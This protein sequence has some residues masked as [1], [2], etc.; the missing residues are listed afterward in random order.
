M[1]L[2]LFQTRIY[3]QAFTIAALC[4]AAALT[5]SDDD[6]QEEQQV[7]AVCRRDGVQYILSVWFLTWS[8]AEKVGRHCRH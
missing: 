6:K 2:K 7:C 4:G 5:M 1:T 3:A 8:G